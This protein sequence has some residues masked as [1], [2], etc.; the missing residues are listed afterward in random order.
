M[1]EKN[2]CEMPVS[3]ICGSPHKFHLVITIMDSNQDRCATRA[4]YKNEN[5]PSLVS[6]WADEYLIVPLLFDSRAEA[7]AYVDDVNNRKPADYV[8]VQE[9]HYLKHDPHTTC[10]KIVAKFSF[11]IEMFP[12]PSRGI[13]QE[14]QNGPDV[15]VTT[16]YFRNQKLAERYVS[17]FN[18]AQQPKGTKST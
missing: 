2:I 14:R 13:T 10:A 7:L 1:E 5:P 4:Y 15:Y 12:Q 16:L 9:R 3:P 6:E 17:A 11:E 8:M 18:A